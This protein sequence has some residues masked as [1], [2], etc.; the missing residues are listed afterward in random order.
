MLHNQRADQ[1]RAENTIKT[2]Q[3][4]IAQ[5]EANA[6]AE[7]STVKQ[8]E[9]AAAKLTM[10]GQAAD[11]AY[12]VARSAHKVKV[13]GLRREASQ[14]EDLLEILMSLKTQLS[15][16]NVN[17]RGSA[18]LTKNGVVMLEAHM[19]EMDSE[20]LVEIAESAQKAVAEVADAMDEENI[21]DAERLMN[22]TALV[23]VCLIAER[24]RER[25]REKQ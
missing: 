13:N 22:G 11:Q 7:S 24:E 18:R 23:F 6:A 20:E 12:T 19:E 2:L 14:A 17:Q 5:D 25:E 15:A 10:E 8:L 4:G 16:V 21:E 1:A 9:A 3:A